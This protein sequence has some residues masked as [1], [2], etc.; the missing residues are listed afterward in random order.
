MLTEDR[1]DGLNKNM[2]DWD[3]SFYGRAFNS[4]CRNSGMPTIDYPEGTLPFPLPL[5]PS[6]TAILTMKKQQTNTSS[7][8]PASTQ[9][10]ASSTP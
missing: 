9:A 2:R 5:I 10:R 7:K 3:A 4:W 6:T 8:S 1:L